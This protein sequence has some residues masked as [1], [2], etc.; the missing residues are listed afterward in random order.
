MMT[1]N[2]GDILLLSMV[3]LLTAP[4]KLFIIRHAQLDHNSKESLN[5]IKIGALDSA[6]MPGQT[7]DRFHW[8]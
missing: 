6:Y 2:T 1:G 5:L 8:I 3:K 4:K 7:D